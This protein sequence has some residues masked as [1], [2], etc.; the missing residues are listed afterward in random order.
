ME[1]KEKYQLGREHIAELKAKRKPMSQVMSK[2]NWFK[3][4]SGSLAKHVLADAEKAGVSGDAYNA[5]R[6]N[7]ADWFKILI[8]YRK[9]IDDVTRDPKISPKFRRELL[10]TMSQNLYEIRVKIFGE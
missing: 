4:L 6:K 3:E 5:L 10:A 1:P 2:S 7:M 9:D 8:A